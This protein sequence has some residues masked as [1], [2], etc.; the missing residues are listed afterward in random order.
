[1]EAVSCELC[2][3]KEQFTLFLQVKNEDYNYDSIRCVN[4]VTN[5]QANNIITKNWG[6]NMQGSF[7]AVD[8]IRG[9]IQ[10]KLDKI[11]T[12]V[13]MLGKRKS[14]QQVI[15]AKMIQFA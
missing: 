13:S 15:L 10:I 4:C 14:D 8:T 2:N 12:A 6:R 1:M 5:T 11:T 3:N 7:D 9:M